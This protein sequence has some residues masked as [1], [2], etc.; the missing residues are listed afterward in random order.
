MS[1]MLVSLVLMAIARS[2]ALIWVAIILFGVGNGMYP[3]VEIAIACDCIPRS[4]D[5]GKFMAEFAVSLTAGQLVGQL[6]FGLSLQ[7]FS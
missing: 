3:S 7:A 5:A 1:L 2:I 6:V 4:R